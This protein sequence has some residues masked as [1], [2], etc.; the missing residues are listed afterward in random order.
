MAF[1][2]CSSRRPWWAA[3]AA[4]AAALAARA[5]D[6]IFVA[7]DAEAVRALDR[8]GGGQGVRMH[9]AVDLYSAAPASAG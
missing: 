5:P 7:D 9:V 3:K 4:R 6:T 1:P 8:A 2:A